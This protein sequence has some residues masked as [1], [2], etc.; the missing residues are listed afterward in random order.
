MI[1]FYFKETKKTSNRSVTH[2]YNLL[3]WFPCIPI[4]SISMVHKPL[5]S[6]LAKNAEKAIEKQSMKYTNAVLLYIF[7]QNFRSNKKC[8]AWDVQNTEYDAT[9]SRIF[10]IRK[11]IFNS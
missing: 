5:Y 7:A 1:K 8:I 6:V 4:L 11:M 3:I 2:F 10:S 9:S